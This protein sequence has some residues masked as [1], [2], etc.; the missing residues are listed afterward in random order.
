MQLTPIVTPSTDTNHQPNDNMTTNEIA[1][2]LNASLLLPSAIRDAEQALAITASTSPYR[3]EKEAELEALKT[4]HESEKVSHQLRD[5][6]KAAGFM[7]SKYDA[8]QWIK[9][10]ANGWVK[11][12]VEEVAALA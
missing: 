11:C 10:T 12:S 8:K 7:R 4:R 6:A 2:L 1:A 5:R 9:K 3:A